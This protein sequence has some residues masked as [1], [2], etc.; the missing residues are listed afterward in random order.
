MVIMPTFHKYAWPNKNFSIRIDGKETQQI[1]DKIEQSWTSYT[2]IPF[3]FYFM[4]ESYDNLYQNEKRTGLLFQVFSG[5]TIF[6]AILGLLGLITFSAEQRTKEIGIRKSMG[7]TVN[8]IVFLLSK[9]YTIWI[10]IGFVIAC[11]IAYAIGKQW[12]QNF[13]YH[14]DISWIWFALSGLLVLFIAW[15]TVSYQSIRA[16]IKNPVEALR[17]E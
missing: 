15:A 9:D 5:L 16:A 17:Y 11:P 2:D 8:Q 7:A 13:A 3:D 12:L 6:I 14:V 4:D 10:G 1:I